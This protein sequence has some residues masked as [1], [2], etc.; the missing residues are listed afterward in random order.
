MLE[1]WKTLD[2][3][4][5]DFGIGFAGPLRGAWLE[6]SHEI[7][8]LPLP[9][10]APEFMDCRGAYMRATWLGPA[11]GWIDPVAEKEGAI[12]GMEA[13]LSTLEMECAEQNLDWE[14]VLD[15]RAREV[16]GFK[17]RGLEVPQSWMAQTGQ[18]RPGRQPQEQAGGKK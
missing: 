18:A 17:E 10:N 8:D 3:R 14:E 1:A 6:E 13:G 11:R 2:R 7:D 9:K 12:M 5:I 15:Q 4:R 16:A